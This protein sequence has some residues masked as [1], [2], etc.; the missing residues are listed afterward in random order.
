[1]LA[2]LL[3]FVAAQPIGQ[4]D[5]FAV[6]WARI[7]LSLLFCLTLAVGAVALLRRRS[8]APPI[9]SFA[10]LLARPDRARERDLEL[11]ERLQL[12]PASQ[13]CLVRCGERRLLL[14]V[15]AAGAQV[16]ARLDEVDGDA[17]DK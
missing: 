7:I 9:P 12:S 11:L 14:H 13:L 8:G 16:L 17:E 10:R 15:A 3:S 5:A 6:P 2:A 1:L 4:A